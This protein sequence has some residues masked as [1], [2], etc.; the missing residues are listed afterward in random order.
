MS[1]SYNIAIIGQTGVGKSALVNYLFG[2]DAPSGTG[3]PVTTKGFHEYNGVLSS[4]TGSIIKINIFDSWGL[5]VGKE[6]EW[7]AMF[8]KELDKRSIESHPKDWFHSVIYCISASSNRVQNADIKI[9]KQALKNEY[10]VTIALTK[11]DSISEEDELSLISSIKSSLPDGDGVII[12]PICAVEKETRFSPIKPFGKEALEEAILTQVLAAISMR[13]PHC[14]EERLTSTLHGWRDSCHYII[15]KE[16]G[17]FN[18][19]EIAKKLQRRTDSIKDILIA[20]RDETLK[21]VFAAYQSTSD[22]HRIKHYK[23]TEEEESTPSSL[24]T[25]ITIGILFPFLA[26]PALVFMFFTEESKNKEKLHGEIQKITR[27]LTAWIKEERRA[28]EERIARA[29]TPSKML[30]YKS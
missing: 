21:S 22:A 3:K 1:D 9:I 15:D 30:G 8:K 6:D 24:G 5:E 17:S 26:I 29:R 27:G 11:S 13:L 2:K 28:V 10:P 14:L 20:K 19:R 7:S 25:N 18:D 4:A 12:V 16:T 23:I